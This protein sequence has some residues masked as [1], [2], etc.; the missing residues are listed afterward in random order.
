MALNED[1]SC[2]FC[3][4]GETVEPLFHPCRC[5]GSIRHIHESCLTRWLSLKS[6]RPVGDCAY[7]T[8]MKDIQCEL[9]G[10]NFAFSTE[11]AC[12]FTGSPG[13]VVS[14]SIAWEM[15]KVILV[16]T[17]RILKPV[18]RVFSLVVL[19]PLFLGATLF[20]SISAIAG[21][22]FEVYD[23]SVL[24]LSESG[25]RQYFIGS[26]IALLGAGL[27]E[28]YRTLFPMR[29]HIR[30][31]PMHSAFSSGLIGVCLSILSLV[32]PYWVGLGVAQK[33]ETLC[34]LGIKPNEI[35]AV[36]QLFLLFPIRRPLS[37]IIFDIFVVSTG[38]VS[39]GSSI[40][41]A[42]LIA[43]S[44]S[45]DER[46][47]IWRKLS[48][49]ISSLAK[50]MCGLVEP[51]LIGHLLMELP[52]FRERNST[53]CIDA[54]I[55][56]AIGCAVTLPTAL[57]QRSIFEIFLDREER[58]KLSWVSYTVLYGRVANDSLLL[59]FTSTL[60]RTAVHLMTYFLAI[61]PCLKFFFE[62]RLIPLASISKTV[63][64]GLLPFELFYIHVLIP[65]LLNPPPIPRRIESVSRSAC[66]LIKRQC[67]RAFPVSLVFLLIA[68]VWSSLMAFVA[69]P[70]LVGRV[71]CMTT[72]DD[73]VSFSVGFLFLLV[74]LHFGFRFA[75][76]FESAG[77]PSRESPSSPMGTF[78]RVLMFLFTSLILGIILPLLVGIAFHIS[79]ITPL[80]RVPQT[81]TGGGNA[82]SD[83]LVP[84]W[85]IG[86]ML[87]KIFF[88]LVTIGAFP[89]ASHTF[90][91]IKA[92]HA[93]EG[94]LSLSLHWHLHSRLVAPLLIKLIV[95]C[96][97]PYFGGHFLK[98]G[99][100]TVVVSWTIYVA[101]FHLLPAAI[102]FIHRQRTLAVNRK[103]LIRA[104]LINLDSSSTKSKQ[105]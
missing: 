45:P 76:A 16:N 2:R 27:A 43:K 55:T 87:G 48:S 67:A 11:Y 9:C 85:I 103:Y 73:F 72:C 33:L 64:S 41:I 56:V 50:G 75:V 47:W 98:L 54:A 36:C 39:I 65:L 71:L 17:I 92:I 38:T 49:I 42:I 82:I 14:V 78:K 93:R 74:A 5:S 15:G 77:S 46:P 53:E 89:S 88:A 66:A 32:I 34:S 62:F 86:V 51:F 97:I 12:E 29:S 69:L 81:T 63:T 80:R 100:F 84:L 25:I 58:I 61:F 30:A 1:A 7:L 44:M 59:T 8:E 22:G 94:L 18:L 31:R 13:F 24:N 70:L 19:L 101:L 3:G 102:A 28:R 83:N 57:I 91:E 105:H 99:D 6:N 104:K 96:Y 79:L 37:D 23:Q 52:T 95:L 60:L 40:L 35:G 68:C 20:L 10:H 21:N 4:D 90:E 26:L